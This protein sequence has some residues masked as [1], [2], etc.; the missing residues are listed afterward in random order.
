MTNH[1]LNILQW[2]VGA[3]AII[4]AWYLWPVFESLLR[5]PVWYWPTLFAAFLAAVAFAGREK[6][7]EETA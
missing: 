7:K 2:G 4:T 1:A 6:R 5:L 3:F